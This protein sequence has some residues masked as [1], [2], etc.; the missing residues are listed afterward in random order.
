MKV[1]YRLPDGTIPVLLSS[2][3][4]ELVRNEA[5]AVLSYAAS[6][7][8][9]TA[10]AI[11]GM[12]FRTR[13]A[14][15]YRA[16]AMVTDRE[17]LISAL[18]AVAD[19]QDHPS[20]VRTG[21][22]ATTRRHAYVFPGQ[23]SQRPG[24]GRLCYESVPA[25]RTE[26]DRCAEEFQTQLGDSP[27]NYLLDEQLAAQDHASIV[28]PA[29]FTQ[30]AGLAA[31]WRSFG[32]R[33]HLTIGH[34]QGE[35]AAAYVAGK[36]TL[37]DAVRVVGIRARAADEFDT[38][39]YAMAVVA[40]DR[41]TC[42]DLLA[43]CAGW[44]ELSVVNSPGMTGI[45]GDRD[46]VQGIVDIFTERGT[47][48]RVI[49]VRYPAHTSVIQR[50]GEKVRTAAAHAL[51]NPKFLDSDIDCLGAT[52]G[53]PLTGDLPVDQ[54]WF[55]N[56]RNTV[57]FDKAV[58]AAIPLGVDTFVE[59]AEHPTLQLAIE[60]N[61]A[62]LAE[63]PETLVIGTSSR[64]AG[65][66]GEFSNNLAQLAVHDLEYPW[67]CLGTESDGPAPL[68]L[69]DFP[70]TVLNEIKFWAPYEQGGQP[71]GRTEFSE[72]APS[73]P[74]ST[75]V[76]TRPRLLTE[77]WVRL[78]Q[79]SLVAP[80]ALGI[81]DHTTAC[82]DLADALCAAASH[83]GATARLVD[84]RNSS[85]TNDLDTYVILLPQ[86]PQLDTAAAAN[87]VA[88]FF[89]DRAWW[90]G[91]RDAV[92]EC[93]LVTVGGEAVLA[94]DDAPDPVHA[95]ASA[96]FRSIG[97][98][99][100]GVRFRHLDLPPAPPP[101]LAAKVLAALHTRDESELAL[102]G[103]G[104]YAK[105]VSESQATPA[106]AAAHPEHVLIIG[107]SGRLGLEFC[108]HFARRGTRRITLVNRSGES[109]AVADRL[110]R[111]RSDTA[112]QIRLAQCDLGDQAAVAQ[113][114]RQ[115][116]DAPADLIVH[117]AVAYSG[118][119]LDDITTTHVDQALQA[120]VVGI[121]RVLETF[122]R[123]DDARV[124]LCSSI[125]ATVGGRGLALYAAA[126]RML[127]AMAHRLQ[128]EGV[129]CVS[130]QWGHWKV[131]LDD[132]GL[133][134]LSGLGVVPML[135][136]DALAVDVTCL[137]KNVIVASFD[138]DRAR[139]VLETCGRQALLAQLNSAAVPAAADSAP[140]GAASVP[141]RL[142]KLLAQAIGVE[143]IQAIDTT[144]PMVAIG[145]DSL[146]ALE[147]RRQVKMEF[148]HDLEVADLLGGASVADVLAKL[149]A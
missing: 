54:Y 138:L 65:D 102:R 88:T 87:E 26:V 92:T 73:P 108:E 40:A 106:P 39:D 137:G 147:F 22:A 136:A 21:S 113:L 128:S 83:L 62:G 48:A 110:Q 64:T 139:A 116:Q 71:R 69:P 79:R 82:V 84:T 16:L 100:P 66:L 25:F 93:W 29:L 32:V 77:E 30:M 6:H 43:R 120:K 126:N 19:E 94:D 60:E 98:Q 35:I 109:P 122:P 107:G 33:P 17:D 80:R 146:Q 58:A 24:M 27:L 74:D 36:V 75:G 127:D 142:V 12:L 53:G 99:Y 10:Q 81:I 67:D 49:R 55:W 119:E 47:F 91:M 86:S 96:G 34:S 89:A 18:Q 141:H 72:P 115:H 15:R 7:P 38:G 125:S 103:G 140:T 76:V 133:A 104:L 114:A 145:L 144:V 132:S 90:P 135:P 68:P 37:S 41:D 59:L 31:T 78:Q 149:D 46:T 4:A 118:V 9:V 85:P 8:E 45:S 131:H 13:V 95:A 44:A 117:A 129:D 61:L 130:V 97:A 56:L 57:R 51:E 105:R 112:T 1:T 50:L 20:V 28:Q 14:R 23:G 148:D 143:G 111:L 121:A 134:M 3:T 11:A 124:I 2:D 101:E 5:A 123:T 52:L 63:L 42:E 70:N